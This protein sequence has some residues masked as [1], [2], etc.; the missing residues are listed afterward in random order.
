MT[1]Q[2][3]RDRFIKEELPVILSDHAKWLRGE[4]G[5]RAD[6]SGRDLRCVKLIYADLAGADL[7]GAKLILANMRG[8]DLTG[9]KGL[10]S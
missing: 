2:P 4:G 6:L 1:D 5:K 7:T 9:A 10:E 3:E 8:A